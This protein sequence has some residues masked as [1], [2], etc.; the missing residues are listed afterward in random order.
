M[1]LVGGF[2][3]IAICLA[4][5]PLKKAPKIISYCLW[6]AAG[7]RLI[8]PFSPRSV[9]SWI[10]FNSQ[11]FPVDTLAPTPTQIFMTPPAV[12]MQPG[13]ELLPPT[14]HFPTAIEGLP[15]WVPL[16]FNYLPPYIREQLI[17]QHL[18]REET[19]NYLRIFITA[20]AVVWLVAA[21]LM[22][23]YGLATYF[24][25][26]HKLNKNAILTAPYGETSNIYK[27]PNIK[28]PFVLGFFEPKI[29]LPLSLSA[30]ELEYVI[31]HEKIHIERRD[32]I[33]KFAAYIVLCLHWFNPLVWLAFSLMEKDMEMS[34]DE[35]VLKEMG[36]GIKKTYSMSL[37]SLAADQ[38]FFASSPLAFGEK[39]TESRVKNVLKFKKRSKIFVAAT[40]LASA[41][42]AAGFLFTAPVPDYEPPYNEPGSVVW[43]TSG[44]QFH[45]PEGAVEAHT[46]HVVNMEFMEALGYF[47]HHD[48]TIVTFGE[49]PQI[50]LYLDDTP[51]PLGGRQI[52]PARQR[53]HDLV[54]LPLE[55]VFDFLGINF[56]WLE[57]HNILEVSGRVDTMQIQL[58]NPY[59]FAQDGV[60]LLHQK[61]D[62]LY[63]HTHLF[64]HLTGYATSSWDENLSFRTTLWT[65][66]FYHDLEK[67]I[68]VTDNR[69]FYPAFRQKQRDM[70][71][72][73]NRAD[74][75]LQDEITVKIAAHER[76]FPANSVTFET[77]VTFEPV[78]LQNTPF[79]ERTRFTDY[80]FFP[81][82]ELMELLSLPLPEIH[83]T[84]VDHHTLLRFF[85]ELNY[86]EHARL[87][88]RLDYFT[89]TLYIYQ[90]PP[91][92][93]T[94]SGSPE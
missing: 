82:A 19:T 65:P 21:L 90:Q 50:S 46:G 26:K 78:T 49:N 38:R 51:I 27:S 57:P 91:I 44:S 48:F 93:E 67:V 71:R 40:A 73:F 14:T 60:P 7:I 53:N 83:A 88:A 15:Q 66:L 92:H 22:L 33:T 36:G 72:E 45:L 20:A 28:S 69:Q 18:T 79:V 13:P 89:S 54:L 74:F 29:Y 55:P 76:R 81:F 4:R 77:S 3:I 87:I 75:S 47:P 59:H 41:V 43:R 58:H 12:P 25:L 34:C 56:I 85:D 8:I 42:F 23:G 9:F 37:V 24:I 63:F 30:N 10:P 11:P 35:R 1:S 62:G 31:L 52:Y 61:P 5:V 86:Y 94:V 80:V 39:S 70:S 17:L 2:V 32:H 6:L 16:E 64:A 84:Y 68:I